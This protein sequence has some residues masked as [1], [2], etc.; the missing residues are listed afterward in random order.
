MPAHAPKP[1]CSGGYTPV[2]L[3]SAADLAVTVYQDELRA[4]D[5]T[6]GVLRDSIRF[7]ST[8]VVSIA[9]DR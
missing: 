7:E 5:L 3:A 8:T 4:W 1:G 9:A 6:R 2:A